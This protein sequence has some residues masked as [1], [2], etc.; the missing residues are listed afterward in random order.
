MD[1]YYDLKKS[2]YKAMRGGLVFVFSSPRNLRRF[3]KLADEKAAEANG[4]LKR[5]FKVKCEVGDIVLIRFYKEC[6]TR[7]FLIRAD[8]EEIVCESCL[9]FDGRWVSDT[10]S[11]EPSLHTTRQ[12]RDSR[13]AEIM[14]G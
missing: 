13:T 2:P 12:S 14:L 5:R 9:R 10:N 7:G 6:E 1:V 3:E 4:S 11:E 8:G